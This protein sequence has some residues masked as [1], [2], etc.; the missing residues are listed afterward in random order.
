[1]KSFKGN[2]RTSCPRIFWVHSRWQL[3]GDVILTTLEISFGVISYLWKKKKKMIKTANQHKLFCMS[4][5]KENDSQN[6]RPR[7][8][9]C[10]STFHNRSTVH[11]EKLNFTLLCRVLYVHMHRNDNIYYLIWNEKFIIFVIS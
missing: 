11:V 10:W 7:I 3:C 4:K 6:L 1:M 8:L 9:C 2:A 5:K